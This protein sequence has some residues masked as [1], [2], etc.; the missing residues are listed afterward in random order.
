VT[1]TP[2]PIGPQITFFGLAEADGRVTTPIGSD[3]E[4]R[5]IY[6][7]GLPQGFLIVVEAKRGA[8]GGRVGTETFN[9]SPS[10]PGVLPDFRLVTSNPLGD[11]SWEVCDNV[12]G[13]LGGVPAIDPP[14]FSG[15]QAVADALNDFG[16]RF[17]ATTSGSGAA[18]CTKEQG[19]M[20][21]IFVIPQSTTQFCSSPGVGAEI[22]FPAGDTRLTV[23][24][25]DVLGYPGP[26]AGIVVRIE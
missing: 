9:W 20:E 15:S 25:W 10:S 26:P 22:A 2:P 24:V 11:G 16:C 3:G 13:D 19:T 21:P 12:P 4:G 1:F 18:P 14:A 7:R 23:R 8:S 17:V 5:P 6:R